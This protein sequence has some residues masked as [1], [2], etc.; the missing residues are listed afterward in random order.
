MFQIKYEIFLCIFMH[1]C[2]LDFGLAILQNLFS[3]FYRF[4][5]R[6]HTLIIELQ[7]NV[8]S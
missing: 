3:R 7:N 8:Y 6:T 5:K 2:W 4:W 1:Q